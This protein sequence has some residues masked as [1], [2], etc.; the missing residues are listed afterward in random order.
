MKAKA[1]KS[2][3]A[4]KKTRSN[5]KK[6][7]EYWAIFYF[8]LNKNI[9]ILEIELDGLIEL[10]SFYL[11]KAKAALQLNLNRCIAYMEFYRKK[12]ERTLR[13]KRK[14]Y[15]QASYII[16]KKLLK[17]IKSKQK[18]Y[19]KQRKLWMRSMAKKLANGSSTIEE[20]IY[21]CVNLFAA[22][23][24]AFLSFFCFV[25]LYAFL[26]LASTDPSESKVFTKEAKTAIKQESHIVVEKK[27]ENPI[28]SLE[29]SP[30]FIASASIERKAVTKAAARTTN[31][32]SY[33]LTAIQ[34]EKIK[35]TENELKAGNPSPSPNT[36]KG[37][38]QD[39]RKG[40]IK[41]SGRPKKSGDQNELVYVAFTEEDGYTFAQH[42]PLLKEIARQRR[43]DNRLYKQKA[44]QALANRKYTLALQHLHEARNYDPKD[45]ELEYLEGE[46]YLAQKNWK[47][48]KQAFQSHLRFRPKHVLTHFRLGQIYY[49]EKLYINAAEHYR[50]V[51]INKP[52]L[53]IARL[54]LAINLI[55]QKEYGEA[56]AHLN[57]ILKYKPKMW[58]AAYYLAKIH[59]ERNEY[60]QGLALLNKHLNANP[61][62]ALLHQGKGEILYK[63]GDF[64]QAA[65]NLRHALVRKSDYANWLLLS[66]ALYAQRSYR[67]SLDALL[68]ARKIY[69]MDP[70]LHYRLGRLYLKLNQ[71]KT[72][73]KSFE[74]SLAINP[75][76]KEALLS[77]LDLYSALA[78]TPKAFARLEETL[79]HLEERTENYGFYI[80]VGDFYTRHKK[81]EQAQKAYRSAI[82]SNSQNPKAYL[83]MVAVLRKL[84]AY[85]QAELSYQEL[86]QNIPDYAEGHRLLGLLYH[87]DMNMPKKAKQ[88][89]EKYLSLKPDS[90]DTNKIHDILRSL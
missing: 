31:R 26:R 84:R 24:R 85:R 34:L 75:A 3:R 33:S 30:K 11:K 19:K 22:R 50:A 69:A 65:R 37:S 70:K 61:Q 51:I 46:L 66:G 6:R 1:K 23:E 89:L 80:Q 21:R 63:M 18:Q 82:K 16:R 71:K 5:T 78:L 42:I 48:A 87:S 15:L 64:K 47:Q 55:K 35:Q 72:A 74:K 2:A 68:K 13:T 14:G 17:E 20:A 10:V 57:R 52:K 4:R 41:D 73:L 43:V 28:L 53:H 8:H 67:Q 54:N 59:S 45:P 81:H 38:S 44:K 49:R 27:V 60:A 32:S 39:L 9:Q 79:Y 90:K 86:L 77:S 88:H 83:R 58:K 25:F 36:E 12:W 62:K 56:A 40:S 76:Y 29:Q 7:K